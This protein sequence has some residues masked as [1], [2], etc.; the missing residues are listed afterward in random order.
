MTAYDN[1]TYYDA[2]GTEITVTD[3]AN[4]ASAAYILEH[5]DPAQ[6]WADGHTY[7]YAT[8]KHFGDA[9]GI[10]RN[11][12]YVLTIDSVTGFGTPVFNDGFVITPEKPEDNEATNLSAT[13]N[14]LSWH[15]VEQNINL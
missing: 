1:I 4:P 9:I 6:I 7:Y 12:C 2:T 5:V 11:H 14:I 10:V 3:P 8:I 15:L 13:I